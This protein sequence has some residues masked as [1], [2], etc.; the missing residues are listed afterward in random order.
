MRNFRYFV[1]KALRKPSEMIDPGLTLKDGFIEW[2]SFVNGGWL[3]P[4]NVYC[5]DYAIRNLPS[6][7]PVLEIGSFAGLSANVI[8]YLLAKHKKQNTF[9]TTDPWIFEVMEQDGFLANT[10][11]HHSQY[12]QHV[13][14]A[15]K[16]NVSF[17]SAARMPHTY[18]LPADDFFVQWRNKGAA[19]DIFSSEAKLGG[20]LSFCYIDGNHLYEFVS[21]DFKNTDEFLEP[22]GF[23]LFDDSAKDFH[24]GVSKLMDE[25]KK[26]PRYRVVI[27]NPNY[28]FQKL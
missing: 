17:F 20:P 10:K 12:R 27:N 9:F 15:Y 19:K 11:I 24:P 22:G 8:S 3:N 21:S 28:L 4:G 7:N 1:S 16:K 25:L 13:M 23:I 6:S 26:N 18:E 14:E 5:M 2:I